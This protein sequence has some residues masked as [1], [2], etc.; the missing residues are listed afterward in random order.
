MSSRIRQHPQ[1]KRANDVLEYWYCGNCSAAQE[2]TVILCYL[3]GV[4]S[5]LQVG[6]RFICGLCHAGHGSHSGLAPFQQYLSDD[7]NGVIFDAAFQVIDAESQLPPHARYPAQ[8]LTVA[9]MVTSH[10]VQP[11]SGCFNEFFPTT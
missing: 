8:K 5:V 2:L 11:V 1:C 3:F 10:P 9:D 7:Y 4:D 6:S